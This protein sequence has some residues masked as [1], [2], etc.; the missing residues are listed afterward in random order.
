MSSLFFIFWYVCSDIVVL[1]CIS[2]MANV[3]HLY[4]CVPAIC[5]SS[6]FFAHSLIGF[7]CR[8][9]MY[10]RNLS[11]VRYVVCRCLFPASSLSFN[12]LHMAF[13]KQKILI[14]PIFPFMNHA[15]DIKS[16][17]S[18]PNPTSQ[19]F[20]AMLFSTRFLFVCFMFYS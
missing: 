15:F 6:F 16:K 18:L 2:L 9:F 3:T 20:S 1:I 10:S 11:F 4:I 14:L 19:G 8:F 13:T 12:L 5:V 17:N 7:F